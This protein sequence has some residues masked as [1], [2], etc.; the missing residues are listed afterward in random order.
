MGGERRVWASVGCAR[1]V[2]AGRAS[3][4]LVGQDCAVICLDSMSAMDGHETQGLEFSAALSLIQN[5][6]DRL[7]HL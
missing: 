6:N 7:Y 1:G 2:D 4:G 5:I 3:E